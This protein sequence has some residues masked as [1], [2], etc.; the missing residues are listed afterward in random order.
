VSQAWYFDVFS[1][2]YATMAGMTWNSTGL[3]IER[4]W[5]L[6]LERAFGPQAKEP[7]RIALAHT[8][9][10]RRFD[11]IARML[12]E[13]R[14]EKPF[15]FWDMYKLTRFNGLTDEMLAELEA[16]AKASLDAAQQARPLLTEPR[17]Q[18]MADLVIISAERRYC[19]A[20][21]GRLYLRARA[22]EKKGD[23]AAALAL[24]EQCEKEGAKLERAAG[25]MGI[26]YPLAMH[27]DD[28]VQVYRQMR[29]RLAAG[30]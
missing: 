11:I 15:Q 13:D 10:D 29:A 1:L 23:R 9:F 5:D 21:S 14:I 24:I 26:E 16:D 27:D 8:R 3:P 12:V 22:A 6:T 4:F 25:R 2:N 18:E 19:L 17:A 28:V 7:M 30:R 20:T